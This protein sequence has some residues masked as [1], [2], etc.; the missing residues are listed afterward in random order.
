[1][2]LIFMAATQAYS[3]VNRS[4]KCH[5]LTPGGLPLATDQKPVSYRV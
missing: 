1:M 3:G 5:K 2:M 4:P